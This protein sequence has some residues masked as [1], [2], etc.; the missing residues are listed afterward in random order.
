MSNIIQQ[1]CEL[2]CYSR[3]EGGDVCFDDRSLVSF[4]QPVHSV[5]FS[6][7]SFMDYIL[8]VTSFFTLSY[9]RLFKRLI[10]EDV[11]ADLNEGYDTFI[12]KKGAL[13][14]KNHNNH[15]DKF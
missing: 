14:W 15:F 4:S 13:C 11:G 7:Y 3:V 2:A 8:N 6:I 9:Q 10:T 12:E 1:P 5:G